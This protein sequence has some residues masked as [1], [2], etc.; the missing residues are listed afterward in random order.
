MEL[1]LADIDGTEL[2]TVDENIDI[3]L[4]KNN[5]FE[6]PVQ[7]ARW[8]G[9]YT[10]GRR[11][12]IPGTEYGG[13]IGEISSVT[14]DEMIYVRGYTWRGLLEGKIIEP[15]AGKDYQIVSGELNTI[16]GTLAAGR[17]DGL[18]AADDKDTGIK[19]NGYR[20]E[21]YCSLLDGIRTM[22]GSVGY[23]L[24]ISY[25]QTKE[26]GYV[27]LEAVPIKDYSNKIEI[28]QDS[29]LNFVCTDSRMGINHLICLGKG[30]LKDRTVVHLYA[31]ADST[32]GLKPYYTGM[33]E[34][35]AVFESDNSERED[36]TE[37]GTE[38][39]LDLMNYV[40]FSTDTSDTDD[41]NMEIGDTISGRDYITGI[42]VKKPIIGKV[43]KIKEQ[44]IK[45]EYKIEG[46]N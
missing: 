20:F 5:D 9:E 42:Y 11:I 40:E 14:D 36:L 6:M 44:D 21:P 17:F 23:R 4:G 43:L 39:L 33:D 32:V 26:A 38:K 35:A 8:Q 25:I 46:D 31:Q 29:R 22:L 13:T 12:Y 24:K 41:I 45:V 28:S 18:F 1:I 37:K 2:K 3:D 19:I 15:E 27:K 16:L 7:Y 34:R 30:E 10:Y